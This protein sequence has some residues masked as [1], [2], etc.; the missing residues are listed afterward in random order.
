MAAKYALTTAFGLAT[1]EEAGGVGRPPECPRDVSATAA[2]PATA[3]TTTRAPA[4]ST[5][6]GHRR[7]RRGGT[8]SGRP[9][10]GAGGVGGGPAA[11]P[12]PARPLRDKGGR[13][14]PCGGGCGGG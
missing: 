3:R 5:L 8:G 14:A 1:A 12:F 2:R 10:P 7:R 4:A 6:P 11:G 13:E 9:P